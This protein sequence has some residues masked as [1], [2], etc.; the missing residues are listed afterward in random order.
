MDVKGFAVGRRR[1]GDGEPCLIVAEVAQAHEGSEALAQTYIRAVEGAGADA[2]K[3]QC[4]L[5]EIESSPNVEWRIKP[6]VELDADRYPYWQRTAFDGYAWRRLAQAAADVGLEFLCSVFSPEGVDEMDEHVPAW[7]VA[8]GQVTNTAA[9]EAMAE[10]GKPA[11]ISMGMCTWDETE[12]CAAHFNDYALLQC[13]SL[14][15]CPP[16]K[17]GLELISRLRRSTG[18]PVGLSDHSASIYAGLAAVARGAD[19]L[20]V[21]V[22]LSEHDLGLDAS[23]SLTVTELATLVEGVRFIEKAMEPVDKEQMAEEL[24]RMRELFMVAS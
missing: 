8:S 7:K 9:L 19:I 6:R 24:G 3:F 5:P 17:L 14:Y 4:H 15:P 2:V 12:A 18:R 10:T 1:V 21:H 23:S 13:T 22:K 11:L 16:E 20:E